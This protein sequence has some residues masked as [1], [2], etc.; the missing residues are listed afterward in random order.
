[1][2]VGWGCRLLRGCALVPVDLD[3][4]GGAADGDDVDLAIGVEVGAG[5]I[6]GRHAAVVDD[7]LFPLCGGGVGCA[8]DVD[9]AADLLGKR[10]AYADDDFVAAIAIE[11]GAPE[12]VAPF[13]FGVDDVAGP[14]IGVRLGVAD[15][16]ITV[17][18]LARGEGQMAAMKPA[19]LDL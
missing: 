15:H 6:L 2:W 8:E 12:A 4:P 14:L 16:L 3:V 19:H 5:E 1:M 18:W 7:V 11:V 9:A 10:V 17:P 13:Q